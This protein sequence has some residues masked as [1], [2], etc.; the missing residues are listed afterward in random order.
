M[1][2]EEHQSV[3]CVV[4]YEVSCKKQKLFIQDKTYV[5]GVEIASSGF[6]I[7]YNQVSAACN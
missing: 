5:E 2:I 4:T 3:E 6:V 1:G 7:S